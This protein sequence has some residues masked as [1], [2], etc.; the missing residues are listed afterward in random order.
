MEHQDSIVSAANK[1]K[2]EAVLM[3]LRRHD[4][5][6]DADHQD[7]ILFNAVANRHLEVTKEIIRLGDF[8]IKIG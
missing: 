2:E 6:L 8:F 3:M 7:E 1:G 5:V 4:V